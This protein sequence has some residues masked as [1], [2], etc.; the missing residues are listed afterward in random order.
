MEGISVYMSE[1]GVLVYSVYT[2]VHA[3]VEQRRHAMYPASILAKAL[4]TIFYTPRG[5]KTMP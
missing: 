5:W 4:L 1:S 3:A 2:T